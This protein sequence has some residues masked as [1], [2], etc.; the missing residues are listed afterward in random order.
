MLTVKITVKERKFMAS[1]EKWKGILWRRL[2][3][4]KELLIKSNTWYIKTTDNIDNIKKCRNI[5]MLEHVMTLWQNN[6][7]TDNIPFKRILFYFNLVYKR[8]S[9]DLT[10]IKKLENKK[11]CADFERGFNYIKNLTIDL[12]GD[13]P[14]I[15]YKL[16]I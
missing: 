10:L 2:A 14:L 8:Y 16:L 12:G 3:S 5:N 7:V 6:I 13:V 1:E 15:V 11:N 9:V 4:P